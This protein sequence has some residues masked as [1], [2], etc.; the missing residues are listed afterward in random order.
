MPNRHFD[1]TIPAPSLN[2][3]A[4]PRVAA[5]RFALIDTSIRRW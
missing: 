3:R 4:N 5:R 2:Q 1:R